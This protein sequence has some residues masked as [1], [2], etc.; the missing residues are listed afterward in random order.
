MSLGKWTAALGAACLSASCACAGDIKNVIVVIGDGM[1]AQQIGLLNSYVKHAPGADY[2]AKNRISAWEKI[3]REGELGLAYTDPANALVVD[4][5]ASA[6]QFASGTLAGSEMVGADQHGDATETMLELARKKGMAT[7]LVSDTR[8][9]HATPA[10]FAA[11]QTHR[12]KENEIAEDMLGTQVDVMLGGG[13]RHWIPKSANDKAG[14][15]H[16]ALQQLTAGSVR[17]KS[18]RKDE[19]NLLKQAQS[20]GYQ[21]AFNKAQLQAA[22][23]DKLLGLFAYSRTLNGIEESHSL[24]DPER[25]TPT[26][27]EM[28]AKALSVLEKNDKG[29]FLM[30]ES[31]LIDWAAHDND[32]GYMLH[33]MLKMDRTVAYLHDW[34]KER[35]DT[36]IIITADHETGGF[37]FSYSRNNLPEGRDLKGDVFKGA[38]FKPNYNFGSYDTLDKLYQQRASYED[39]FVEFDALPE[40]EQTPASLSRLVN[41]YTQFPITEAEA[42]KVLTTE[43]HEYYVEGHGYLGSKTFPKV[44]EFKEFFVYGAGVRHNLLASVVGKQQNTVWATGTHTNTPVPVVAWGPDS[45]TRDFDGLMHTTDWANRVIQT[46]QAN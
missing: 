13:L 17:I 29:F 21:L 19:R 42:A 31:G 38:A 41:Q 4:S 37:G 27:Q 22:S 39:I 24:N 44:N 33:E 1:G 14:E 46:I 5:A 16:Q 6:T 12:S 36:L 9:T 35:D 43:P 3:A 40:T 8:V 7:G 10:G 28:T 11:H 23:G 26:L 15:S 30:V 32:T 25:S 34:A 45:V 20:Q 18:K 2:Q